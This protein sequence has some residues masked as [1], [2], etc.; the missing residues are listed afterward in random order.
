MS[1]RSITAI[2]LAA[3]MQSAEP[4]VVIDVRRVADFAAAETKIPTATWN[5]PEKIGAWADELPRERP[6]VLYCVKGL[7]V[8]KDAAA[9]LSERGYNAAFLEGGIR[10]WDERG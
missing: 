3:Q 8:G 7:S 1:E 10:A 5:D 4:P 6:I 9:Y 2:E